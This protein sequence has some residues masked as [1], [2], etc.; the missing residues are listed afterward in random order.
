MS[1]KLYS[2]G[3]EL[4]ISGCWGNSHLSLSHDD[5][6]LLLLLLLQRWK[7]QRK[8]CAFIAIL[9]SCQGNL[10]FILNKEQFMF[11]KGLHFQLVIVILYVEM[12][13]AVTQTKRI[14]F[15][16]KKN[17]KLKQTVKKL[18]HFFLSLSQILKKL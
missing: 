14:L 12:F 6:L 2:V 18:N 4:V 16:D 10:D 17:P 15:L 1:E 8:Y 11:I 5:L 13:F 7:S 9:I 3:I